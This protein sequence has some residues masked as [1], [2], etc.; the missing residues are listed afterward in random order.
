MA[1]VLSFITIITSACHDSS[2]ATL[3]AMSMW[4]K[5][6]QTGHSLCIS[7]TKVSYSWTDPNSL[8]QNTW[9]QYSRRQ[10][11]PTSQKGPLHPATKNSK[12]DHKNTNKNKKI[13]K[14]IE[15]KQIETQITNRNQTQ[16][17]PRSQAKPKSS[18][19]PTTDPCSQHPHARLQIFHIVFTASRP[20]GLH[21]QNLE[22][23]PLDLFTLG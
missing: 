12:L 23:Q 13:K 4:P 20:H 18:T 1:N 3:P 11:S 16:T 14:K 21:N 6:W 5:F 15:T 2:I 9:A 8:I 22:D 10:P 17:K 7:Q 19:D